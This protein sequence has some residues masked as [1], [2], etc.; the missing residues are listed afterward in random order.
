MPAPFP[1]HVMAKPAG[2]RCNLDCGYCFYLS[3]SELYPNAD[4]RMTSATLEAFIA[5]YIAAQPGADVHFT[6]QGGEPT[7]MGLPYY[8]EVL[9]LQKKHAPPG[10]RVHN[11][12]QTNAVLLDDDW[13]AFL[14]A[15]GFLVGVSLDGPPALHDAYRR[16][17]GGQP[18]SAAAL[19]GLR[20]LQRAKADFNILTCVHA[21][22]QDHPLEV[23]R[24]LRDEIGAEYMQFIP[25][26]RRLPGKR[27]AARLDPSS[28][29]AQGYGAF[30]STIF[31]EWVRR[32]VGRIFVQAFEEAVAAWAGAPPGLCV[33]SP[34]CGRAL[35]V[36]HN[37]DVYS[38]DHFV[39]PRYRLGNIHQQPLAQLARLP[40]QLQFGEAKKT[41]LP[42]QCR[43]CPVLFA[44]RGGCPK[45]R[46][47]KTADGEAGLN[48]LCPGYLA[49][50]QYI[51]ARLRKVAALLAQ[52]RAAAEIMLTPG[53]G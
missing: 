15:N 16:N 51:D 9:A 11:A 7:L 46:F 53:P 14:A 50:F 5:Q 27:G 28:V 24:F 40:Q 20:C 25:V 18:T 3:R 36:E 33:V 42:T 8:E 21:A 12:L 48:Y 2:A 19:A 43:A 39:A 47:L 49:F 1:F 26:V 4:L 38:C 35:A 52:G 41:G 10:K 17:K 37:G 32:D 30:L 31:D 6:W 44:C 29:T 13:A 23:Y 45:D 34:T 22:N